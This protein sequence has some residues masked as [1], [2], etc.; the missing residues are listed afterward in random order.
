MA[1][2]FDDPLLREW[3]DNNEQLA[4]ANVWYQRVQ[5]MR[6]MADYY[7]RSLLRD[8][9]HE[10]GMNWREIAE[11]INANLDSRQAAR[12]KWLRLVSDDEYGHRRRDAGAPGSWPRGRRRSQ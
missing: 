9:Y 11:V 2:S 6:Q 10:R 12:Q 7:E 8:L 4:R 1:D 3:Q 5:E